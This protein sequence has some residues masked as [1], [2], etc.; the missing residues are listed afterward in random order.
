MEIEVVINRVFIIKYI[1][2]YCTEAIVK[3]DCM[4][5]KNAYVD[6]V[7]AMYSSQS[8]YMILQLPLVR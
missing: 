5:C 3:M 4:H 6:I 7:A 8:K 1:L 2:Q